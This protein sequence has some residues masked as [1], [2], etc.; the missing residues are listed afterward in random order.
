[1][2]NESRHYMHASSMF[3]HICNH[4]LAPSF[5][6]NA[7]GIRYDGNIVE[8]DPKHGRWGIQFPWGSEN[9][10]L[11]DVVKGFGVYCSGFMGSTDDKRLGLRRCSVVSCVKHAQGPKYNQ[12]CSAHFREHS[13]KVAK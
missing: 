9:W 3:R 10:K 4:L 12:M 13:G 8:H 11:D 1:M 7:T 5:L 6:K 2:A